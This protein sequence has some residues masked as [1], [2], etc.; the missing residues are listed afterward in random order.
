[1][2]TLREAGAGG[3][4]PP[5]TVLE[6]VVLPVTPCSRS[7]IGFSLCAFS[8]CY[9]RIHQGGIS[10]RLKSMLRLCYA[11]AERRNRTSNDLAGRLI[12][13]QVQC[14]SASSAFQNR[15]S[16]RLSKNKRSESLPHSKR[17]NGP[18]L[19][20]LV[21]E[22]VLRFWERESAPAGSTLPL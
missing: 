12:Y 4:E 3:V 8:K 6:T 10:H 14:H 17:R 16:I 5:S 15:A 20:S 11:N 22:L 9:F 19:L 2:R 7:S 13:S 1:M 18:L 21:I